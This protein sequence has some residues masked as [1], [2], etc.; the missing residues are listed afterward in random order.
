[1]A[2]HAYNMAGYLMQHLKMHSLVLPT[3]MVYYHT[4]A[5]QIGVSGVH[6]V[7]EVVLICACV[8]LASKVEHSRVRLTK[9]IV[10]CFEI[11]L[12]E[13]SGKAAEVYNQYKRMVLGAEM[14]VCSL[15][16]FEF[17]RHLPY[18]RLEAVLK[19]PG[20]QA[21]ASPPQPAST[22]ATTSAGNSAS[23]RPRPN[24]SSKGVAPQNGGGG[25]LYHEIYNHCSA[26]HVC[27]LQ[28][29]F[30]ASLMP[31]VLADALVSIALKYLQCEDEEEVLLKSLKNT[32]SDITKQVEEE[33]LEVLSEAGS[34]LTR[35]DQL[36]R[37]VKERK[38]KVAEKKRSRSAD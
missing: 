34:A 24:T 23:Q 35:I 8:L 18:P 33:L 29:P 5:T 27:L 26:L 32:T 7:N 13:V 2:R 25:G 3:A 38:I 1:M 6:E 17:H 37:I 36:N 15:L 19:Q 4:V 11:D 12:P 9:L 22:A 21:S 10:A 14:V 30:I 16:D 20:Q 28:S 31:D